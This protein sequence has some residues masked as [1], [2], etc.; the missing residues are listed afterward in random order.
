MTNDQCP[1]NNDQLA[2]SQEKTVHPELVEGSFAKPF[3]LRR[4]SARTA[5]GNSITFNE[6][7][8]EYILSIM[9]SFVIAHC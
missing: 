7:V 6:I 5:Y 8:K 3:M 2:L 9:D 4:R 1:M